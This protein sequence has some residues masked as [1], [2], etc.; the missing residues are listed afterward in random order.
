MVEIGALEVG[1][2]AIIGVIA[3][4]LTVLEY[5]KYLPDIRYYL[6]NPS[7]VATIH[8]EIIA[9][10]YFKKFWRPMVSE[11]QIIAVLPSEDVDDLREGTQKYDHVGLNELTAKLSS[12]FRDVDI[13]FV[14]DDG[15]S[16]AD[17][18]HNVI[19]ASGPIPN[20]VT[21]QLLYQPHVPYKFQRLSTGKIT[22]TVVSDERDVTLEFIGEYDDETG[23]I[24]LERDYGIITRDVNP[25]DSDKL[26]INACGGF[27][28]GTLAGFRILQDATFLRLFERHGGEH[29]QAVYSVE[30]DE[31][32]DI[33]E[34]TLVDVSNEQGPA[35]TSLSREVDPHATE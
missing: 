25:Y 4:I 1:I 15:I 19:C 6:R 26:M 31:D 13:R 34:P 35:I 5:L 14:P 27:G 2:I 21:E 9:S 18:Q 8:Q 20:Q 7:Q 29:F 3:S 11:G 24:N 23:K 22:N 28:E 10:Y 33:K 32:G 16:S 12:K 17:K 30:V